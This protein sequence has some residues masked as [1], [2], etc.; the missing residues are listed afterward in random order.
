MKASELRIGNL[1]LD[2]VLGIVKVVD[3][4]STNV[5]GVQT[6]HLKVNKVKSTKTF[7]VDVEDL[8]PIPLNEEKLLKFGWEQYHNTNHYFI[9]ELTICYV[10]K[11]LGFKIAYLDMV[12]ID[13]ISIKYVHQL[14]NLYFALTGEELKLKQN[15]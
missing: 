11:N 12:A 7:M 9:G 13:S 8:Q 10:N 15:D 2:P 3:I 4:L 14:Q 5:I 6:S 1:V